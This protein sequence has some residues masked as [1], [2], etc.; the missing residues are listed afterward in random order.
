MKRPGAFLALAALAALAGFGCVSTAGTNSAEAA[1][2]PYNPD[3]YQAVETPF[4]GIWDGTWHGFR[5]GET[6]CR[7]VFRG[8]TCVW[9]MQGK[10]FV[11]GAFALEEA[12][13]K[14]EVKDIGSV[15]ARLPG[16]YGVLAYVKQSDVKNPTVMFTYTF[17]GSDTL[18]INGGDERAE[19]KKTGEIDELAYSVAPPAEDPVLPGMD[20]NIVAGTWYYENDYPPFTNTI[21]FENGKFRITSFNRWGKSETI[22]S[23][24]YSLADETITLVYKKKADKDF[25]AT[26]ILHYQ[27]ENG[28]LDILK[29][30]Q[31]AAILTAGTLKGRYSKI[32]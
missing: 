11:R 12:T 5:G 24:N 27:L 13:L 17:A 22:T 7:F 8:N 26:E 32:E 21:R 20:P 19:L 1:D 10:V 18:S 31:S 25:S 6:P 9:Y 2:I 29:A 23:G 30:P 4:A 16:I 3:F 28:A 14:L 15:D